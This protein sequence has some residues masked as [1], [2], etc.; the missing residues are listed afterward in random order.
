MSVTI[1]RGIDVGFVFRSQP[2]LYPIV[3][4]FHLL[5]VTVS[6]FAGNIDFL[7]RRRPRLDGRAKRLNSLLERQKMILYNALT[8]TEKVLHVACYCIG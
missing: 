4:G 1:S 5:R 8:Q 3:P 2:E 7:S 6:R